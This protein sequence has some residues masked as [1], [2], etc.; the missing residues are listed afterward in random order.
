MQVEDIIIQTEYIQLGKFLKLANVV[1]SGGSVKIFLAEFTVQINGESDQR[2]GRKLYPGD[3]VEI[4][5][6]GTFRIVKE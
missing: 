5:D 4:E 2:R 3:Q 6:V 1:D